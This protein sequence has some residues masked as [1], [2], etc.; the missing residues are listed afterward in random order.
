[1]EQQNSQ[2]EQASATPAAATTHEST[3]P[4]ASWL[5]G[6]VDILS[7]PEDLAGRMVTYP[8]RVIVF[9]LLLFAF[10]SVAVQYLYSLNDAIGQQMFSMQSSRLEEMAKKMRWSDN[11]LEEQLDNIRAAL[12]FSFVKNLGIGIPITLV[13]TFLF[14]GMFWI[15]QRLFNAEPPPLVIIVALA[16]YGMS[17][18]VVGMIATGLMQFAGNSLVVAPSAA[19]LAQPI[20]D[21][22]LL[23]QFLSGLTLF[24]VWEYLAVGVV[25]ARHVRMSRTQG[26]AFGATALIIRSIVFGG[27]PWIISLVT[28]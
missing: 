4:T 15:L 13:S 3:E 5:Q 9:S 26:L 21:H 14:G 24:T 11:Q 19:F 20:N 28:G 2:F 16:S 25:V 10:S 7:A 22:P 17:I 12:K 18:T 6:F 27:V 23:F 8:A 1:M